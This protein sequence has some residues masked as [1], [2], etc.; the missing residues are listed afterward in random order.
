MYILYIHTGLTMEKHAGNFR[1]EKILKCTNSVRSD[2]FHFWFFLVFRGLKWSYINSAVVW[3]NIKVNDVFLHFHFLGTL[4]QS[5]SKMS[6]TFPL[7]RRA[8]E[9]MQLHFRQQL[10][11][12]RW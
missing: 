3:L 2:S 9:F 11:V 7:T 5:P 10:L 12:R 6:P 1:V 4:E 8:A